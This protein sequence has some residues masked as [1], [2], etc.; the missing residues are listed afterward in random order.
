[1]ELFDPRNG[2]ITTKTADQLY[3]PQQV[4]DYRLW[5]VIHDDRGGANWLEVPLH[6]R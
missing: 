2:R 6:A 1:M 5:A 3:A 4:G